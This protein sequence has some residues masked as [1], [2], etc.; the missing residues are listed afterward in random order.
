VVLPS[1]QQVTCDKGYSAIVPTGTT[2]A[3]STHVSKNFDFS[4]FEYAI[5][6]QLVRL[7]RAATRTW[8][9]IAAALTHR[10]AFCPLGAEA[11]VRKG[12]I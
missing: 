12:S 11:N 1:S 9:G 4:Q 10:R 6:V 7:R 8:F 2:A 3:G 5:A